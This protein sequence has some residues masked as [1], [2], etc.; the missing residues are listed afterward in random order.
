MLSEDENAVVSNTDA[1]KDEEDAH[2]GD[3]VA[4]KI[5]GHDTAFGVVVTVADESVRCYHRLYER[6]PVT[7][8]YLIVAVK[9]LV[10]DAFVVT[11][12]FSSRLKRGKVVWPL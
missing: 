5:D 1:L 9:V 7:R 3:E 10:D 11:A 12:F 2:I 6:T 4:L 8:K